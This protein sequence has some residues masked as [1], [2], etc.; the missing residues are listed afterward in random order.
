MT[1]QSDTQKILDELQQQI[2]EQKSVCDDWEN[3]YCELQ[4][5]YDE[6]S[7]SIDDLLEYIDE[8]EKK[9]YFYCNPFA[10]KIDIKQVVDKLITY[11]RDIRSII[12]E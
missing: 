7:S 12:N 9:M 5:Q 6:L 11:K 10:R 8:L 2:Q 3:D 1:K 4:E